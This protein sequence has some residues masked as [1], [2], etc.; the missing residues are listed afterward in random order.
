[1]KLAP[2]VLF[3]YNR[4]EH[5]QRTV[6]ALLKNVQAKNSILFIYSDGP[7]DNNYEPVLKVREYINSISG[8]KSIN[9]IERPN[10]IGLA[11]N[12][13]QGIT[14]VIEKF[15]KAI[16]LED[17]LITSPVFLEYMNKGLEMY[18]SNPHIY[19]IN[20]FMFPITF[21][22]RF[23]TF[24]C[25]VATSSWGWATWKN[26]WECFLKDS[27]YK[28]LIQSNKLLKQRF[29]LADYDYANML[30]NKNS[31]AIRWY[32]S[33]FIKNGLGLFPTQ[34]LVQNI[35]FDG[36]GQHNSNTPLESALYSNSL[37]LTEHRSINL[38]Y[39]SK[40]L[41]FFV[42]DK[43]EIK[44]QKKSSIRKLKKLIS[45]LIP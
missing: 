40:L 17:D 36:S 6:E 13:I 2:I 14:E 29:N 5:T 35:G 12:V 26:R 4:P 21:N 25:P 37:S 22:K 41:D 8:F 15:E 33:V 24:L 42:A 9:V 23:E 20:G 34:T 39:Y 38:S 7:K 27:A 16:V 43:K 3:V 31:W 19:S 44:P 45:N 1:M 28:N 10:N 32:Y 18:Q 11:N 30:D